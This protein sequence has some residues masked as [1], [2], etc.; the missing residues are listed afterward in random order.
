MTL[1]FSECIRY[2]WTLVGLYWLIAALGSKPVARREKPPSQLFHLAIMT[3]ACGLLFSDSARVGFL[4]TRLLPETAM[5]D[6]VGLGLTIAGCV[7]AIWARARLG[8]NWSASVTRKQGHEFIRG[9]PYAIVRHPI[10]SGLLLGIL[11]TALAQGELRGLIALG[12]AFVGWLTKARTEE[13]FLVEEF[14][15]EYA[16]YRRRVKQLIPFVF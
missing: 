7:F 12:L 1:D 9:G 3:L 13:Q 10:Y 6:W 11:G 2:V 16:T 14:G 8:S 5:T 4:G 15:S